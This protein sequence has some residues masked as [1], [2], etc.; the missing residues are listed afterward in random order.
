[1]NQYIL[2]FA[3]LF[4]LGSAM[5]QQPSDY[6]KMI[7]VEDL[8]NYITRLASDGFEG[9]ETGRKGQKKAADFIVDYY[10]AIGT[11]PG[12][13]DSYYQHF[14]IA[15]VVLGGTIDINGVS[16]QYGKDFIPMFFNYAFEKVFETENSLIF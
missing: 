13:N 10:K 12:N 6:A 8:E 16:L 1:M 9:R 11:S 15:Q 2:Y 5:A 14:K 4:F 7:D 3:T